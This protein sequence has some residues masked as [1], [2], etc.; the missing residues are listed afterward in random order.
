MPQREKNFL[1]KILSWIKNLFQKPNKEFNKGQ[2]D[3]ARYTTSGTKTTVA[4]LN[5]ELEKIATSQEDF[6]SR[7]GEAANQ[8][9]SDF[10]M[11]S[12]K[13]LNLPNPVDPT[14]VVRL[15]D[16]ALSGGKSAITVNSVG[17][18]GSVVA[19]VNQTIFTS[20][21]QA[22]YIV[23]DSNSYTAQVGDATLTNGNIAELRPR[24]DNSW[25]I[26]WFGGVPNKGF[27]QDQQVAFDAAALRVNTKGIVD[28]FTGK[29]TLGAPVATATMWRLAVEAGIDGLGG[30][31]PSFD[32]D[33]SYL[34]G[35]MQRYLRAEKFT[36]L[37]VGET[38]YGVQKG[39]GLASQ[40]SV[41]GASAEGRGGVFGGSVSSKSNTND[42][43]CI[44]VQGC[45][46]NDNTVIPRTAYGMYAEGKRGTGAAGNTY[47]IEVAIAND[48]GFVRSSP[49]EQP[50]DGAGVT[51]GLWISAG[52][53]AG[54]DLATA[55][56][57]ILQAGTRFDK[58]LL[59][60]NQSL[61]NR[62]EYH[63]AVSLYTGCALTWY[64]NSAAAPADRTTPMAF[65]RGQDKSGTAKGKIDIVVR[66]LD[67][68]PACAYSFESTQLKVTDGAPKLGTVDGRWSEVY[69]INGAINTSDARE[70]Q[71]ILDIE[72]TEALVANEIKASIKK[73]KWNHAVAEKGLDGARIHFGVIAQDVETA[74]T[75]HGLNAADYGL[76]CYDEWKDEFNTDGVQTRTAGNRYG[77]RYEELIMFILAAA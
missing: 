7:V 75:N 56:A 36:N 62:G 58:G 51:T 46:V 70:K 16:L 68:T 28:V 41:M 4:A 20:E 66:E 44:G 49:N 10:D 69:S 54:Y 45:V 57:T 26:R 5:T 74:F 12:N 32:T 65:I 14:D 43:G 34:T 60:Y 30:V 72:A 61:V 73:F 67:S 48:D 29:Y 50:D 39:R 35:A 27:S 8:M 2:E 15:K 37:H 42:Q 38:D 11:N 77:I 47:G 24:Q 25:D 31:A 59:F 9:E 1:S 22:F 18:V 6:V 21:E 23:R 3:M 13:I 33:T 76:F 55:A 63:E 17:L 40:A 52:L 53:G 64:P 19:D 71:Q